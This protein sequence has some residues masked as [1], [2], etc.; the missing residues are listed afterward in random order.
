M[1]I[2]CLRLSDIS[3]IWRAVNPRRTSQK[4]GEVSCTECTVQRNDFELI[5]TVT[6]ETRNPVEGYFGSKFSAICNH[7]KVM[8]A[9]SRKT[10][11]I[12][13]IFWPL[14]EKF[15]KFCSKS[16]HRDTDRRVVFKFR[17]IRLTENRWNRA[18]LT[19]QKI[20]LALQ[21]SLLS[22]SCQ[23][24]VGASPRQCTQS[25]PDFIQIGSLSV[26]L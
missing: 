9:W 14:T 22:G 1:V 24:F 26:E 25:A 12:L 10:I 20:R 16:F 7:C 19:W 4:F 23:K 17:E 5:P 3:V 11:N 6:M 2:G 15:S 8:T 13:E 21:L 18:L